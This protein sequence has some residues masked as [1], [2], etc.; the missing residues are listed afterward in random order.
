MKTKLIVFF[1]LV[2]SLLLGQ[3]KKSTDKEKKE[4]TIAELTKGSERLEG[5][6]TLYQDSISGAIK[7]SIHKDQLN[8]DYI[9]FAPP[10]PPNC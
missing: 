3:D 1:F 7:M 5:L 2:T 6:F 8:K 4:K 9:Y 10:P